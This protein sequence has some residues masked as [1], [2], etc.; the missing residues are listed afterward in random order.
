MMVEDERDHIIH[1]GP[2]MT[3]DVGG[4]KTHHHD[5]KGGRTKAEVVFR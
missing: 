3:N 5:K 1:N 2:N 4:K